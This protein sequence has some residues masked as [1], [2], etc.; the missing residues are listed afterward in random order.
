MDHCNGLKMTTKVEAPL[1][2]DKNGSEANRYFPN[3]YY[4]GI[5]ILFYLASNTILDISFVVHHC[6]WFTH[7]PK[8]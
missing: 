8:S 3:S 7:N 5:G 6:Y 4:S 2:T 1:V